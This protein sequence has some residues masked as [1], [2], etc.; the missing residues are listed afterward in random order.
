MDFRRINVLVLDVDGVLTD[1]T[2]MYSE[3]GTQIKTFHVHDGHALKLWQQAGH[4]AAILSARESPVVK[5][6]AAELG[7]QHVEQGCA[8]K[9]AGYLRL[10]ERLDAS[11]EAVCY[12]GDDAPDL[13][14][15]RRCAFSVAPANA[16]AAVKRAARYVTRRSGGSGAVAEVI[17]L[18]L[19]KQGLWR[20]VDRG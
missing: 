7:V 10:L 8:D 19:R 20:P 15:M 5:R 12:I 13:G 6:R 16:V 14:P 3:S 4:R 9:E 1:G 11:D 2:L 17:E 18:M